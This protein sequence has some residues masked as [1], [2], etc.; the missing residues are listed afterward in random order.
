MKTLLYKIVLSFVLTLIHLQGLSAAEHITARSIME[1]VDA[2][3]DGDRSTAVIKMTLIDQ[4][5]KKRIRGLRSFGLKKQ[6][7]RYSL[8]FVLFPADVRRTG[9]LTYDFDEGEKDDDQWLYLPALNKT[10][11]IA[12]RDKSGGFLGSDF[13][14]GDFI[15]RKLEDYSYTFHKDKSEMVVYGNNTWVIESFPLEAK[16]VEETGYSRSLL[17]VR[18]DNYMV[19]RAIHF[20]KKGGYLKYYD[21]KRM[22]IVN[23][24]WTNLEIHMTKK[25][26]TRTVHKTILTTSEVKYNQPIVNENIFTIRHMEKGL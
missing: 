5:G 6:E 23:G 1:K 9:F 2:V 26:G 19:V 10:K 14:Y 8:M 13:S 24:I 12:S 7:D 18:Q 16:T 22:E 21:V 4:H 3:D 17:F 11:R 20:L 15:K 25:K